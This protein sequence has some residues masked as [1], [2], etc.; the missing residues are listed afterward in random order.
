[1]NTILFSFFSQIFSIDKIGRIQSPTLIIHGT[2]D[3]IIGIDHG[4]ELF[5]HLSYPL[6]PAWIEGAGHNDIELFS[7]YT[8]RLEKFFNEDLLYADKI[9][10]DKKITT[11]GDHELIK[12]KKPNVLS[13]S[14]NSNSTKK[15]SKKY[16]KTSSIISN[17]RSQSKTIHANL[18]NHSSNLIC[19][20][21]TT[22]GSEKCT[23]TMNNSDQFVEDFDKID[24]NRKLYTDDT[25]PCCNINGV[26]MNTDGKESSCENNKNSNS[27][28]N[29][30]TLFKNEAVLGDFNNNN[31]NGVTVVHQN[32]LNGSG[33][34]GLVI[35]ETVHN[36]NSSNSDHSSTAI[37]SNQN[38]FSGCGTYSSDEIVDNPNLKVA[39]LV[40]DIVN[41]ATSV[42]NPKI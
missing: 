33:I 10:D 36:K 18:N 13:P 34:D 24:N 27:E 39:K 40:Q 16:N 15:S 3:E 9:R 19:S 4:R 41:N 17:I 11:S 6:E 31:N 30:L 7:E 1:M 37:D 8:T 38:N 25:N 12:S 5:A 32:E 42:G 22:L 29:D 28:N 23:K 2:E 26:E 20:S 14:I 35:D 21:S